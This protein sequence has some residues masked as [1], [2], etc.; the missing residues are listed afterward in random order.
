MGTIFHLDQCISL[1]NV[2]QKIFNIPGHLMNNI[3]SN[4]LK[5]VILNC[6]KEESAKS[7]SSVLLQAKQAFLEISN[8][9]GRRNIQIQL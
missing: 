3:I 9:R 2:L 6:D 5:L 7:I 1:P 8:E 4:N